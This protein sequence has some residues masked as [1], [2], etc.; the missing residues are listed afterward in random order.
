MGRNPLIEQAAEHR[1]QNDVQY[2]CRACGSSVSTYNC[3]GTMYDLR[4]ELNDDPW[5]WW[6]AC[7]A[8]DCKHT[9]GE[10]FW[11]GKPDWVTQDDRQNSH[12]TP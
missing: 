2:R 7:D 3:N 11:Q 8:G 10:G 4:P 1:H 5:D 6:I 9:H 12:K